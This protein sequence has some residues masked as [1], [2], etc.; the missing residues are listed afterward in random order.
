MQ[1]MNRTGPEGIWLGLAAGLSAQLYGYALLNDAV[2]G[3]AK[4]LIVVPEM[5]CLL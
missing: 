2:Q 3:S 4:K 1:H 5:R